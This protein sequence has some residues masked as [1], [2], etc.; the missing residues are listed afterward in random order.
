[1]ET[2]QLQTLIWYQPHPRPTLAYCLPQ[3]EQVSPDGKL[4][5]L[6][7]YSESDKWFPM[8]VSLG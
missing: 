6:Q 5:P 8:S 4:E 3:V 7:A 1:M 2:E